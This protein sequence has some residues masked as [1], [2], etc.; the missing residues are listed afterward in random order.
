MGEEKTVKFSHSLK[1]LGYYNQNMEYVVEPGILEIMVGNQSGIFAA[2][3]KV[4]IVG[5]KKNVKN[6]SVYT[7]PVSME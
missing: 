6:R 7:C 5:E 4:E 3:G 2:T 1:Q